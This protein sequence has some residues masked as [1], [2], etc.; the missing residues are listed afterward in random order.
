MSMANATV[1]LSKDIAAKDV[2]YSFTAD[3]NEDYKGEGNCS[4]RI[5]T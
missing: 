5:I 2:K 1:K 4:R 3:A